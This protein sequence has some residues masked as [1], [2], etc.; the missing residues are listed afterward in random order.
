M[1]KELDSN[2]VDE[3]P[4]SMSRTAS[5]ASGSANLVTA[6]MVKA[7]PASYKSA[8]ASTEAD[9]WEAAV[10]SEKTFLGEHD[11]FKFIAQEEAPRHA[12]MIDGKWVLQRKLKVDGSIDK[13][14]ARLVA[15]G[16]R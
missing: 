3:A 12:N 16:D 13:H 8:M 9:Q 14:K 7:G 2:L 1:V 11:A 5:G 10:S 15:R 6:F 4:K